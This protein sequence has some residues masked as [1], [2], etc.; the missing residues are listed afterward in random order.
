MKDS[1]ITKRKRAIVLLR[2]VKVAIPFLVLI[3]K[4]FDVDVFYVKGNVIERVNKLDAHGLRWIMKEYQ[5]YSDHTKGAFLASELAEEILEKIKLSKIYQSVEYIFAKDEVKKKKLE[6]FWKYYMFRGIGDFAEQYAAA[7]CLKKSERYKSIWIISYNSLAYFTKKRNEN[8]INIFKLP[9]LFLLKGLKK[10]GSF[11]SD[12]IGSII[13]SMRHYTDVMTDTLMEKHQRSKQFNIKEID[14]VYF[15]HQG[16]FYGD[17]YVKDHYYNDD[18]QSVFHKSKI[19]HISLGEIDLPHMKKSIEYYKDNDIPFVDIKDIGYDKASLVKNILKF[20]LIYKLGFIGDLVRC[21]IFFI[22]FGLLIFI[23]LCKYYLIFSRFSSLKIVLLGYEYNFPITISMALSLLNIKICAT[24]ER[25]IQAFYPD[26]YYILD[27]YFVIGKKVF[28]RGLKNCMIDHCIPIG[29]VREDNLFYYELSKFHDDKYDKIK[30]TRKL[31]L[32]L[33]F[34]APK[35]I[36]EDILASAGKIGQLRQFYRDLI[37]LAKEFPMAHIVIKGKEARSYENPFIADIIEEIKHLQN[38]EIELDIEKYNPYFISEK[39]DLTIGCHTSLCD[40]LIAAD[41]KVIIY[42]L[43]NHLDTLFDYEGLPIIV[44]DYEGLKY[45]L[46]RF[47][48]GKYLEEETRSKLR[49]DFY[50]NCYHGNVRKQVRAA[51]E[52]IVNGLDK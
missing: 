21:G 52:N 37:M 24:Q 36:L 27:Y 13:E 25:F 6:V 23:N 35:N 22:A 48:Q 30:K 39:A 11:I 34:H 31:I 46:N 40:E 43:S 8:G 18:K 20:I 47:L 3:R 32:A 44:K 33:D 19:L 1:N 17:L 15:P 14:V 4:I 7:F 28:E 41:R 51:L 29:M 38:I 12:R 2:I 9:G 16:V 42:Q 50:N 5:D 49:S 10:V 45:H 26:S